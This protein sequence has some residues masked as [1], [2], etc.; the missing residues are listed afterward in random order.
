MKTSELVVAFIR[1]VLVR[2]G[3]GYFVPGS[4]TVAGKIGT[5]TEAKAGSTTG[6]AATVALAA[7]AD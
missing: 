4:F 1:R 3:E 7:V 6:T 5:V 2:V